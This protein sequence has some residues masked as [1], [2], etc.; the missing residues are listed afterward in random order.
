MHRRKC[1]FKRLKGA[2]TNH[3]TAGDVRGLFRACCSI[4][5][6]VAIMRFKFK[7]EIKMLKHY[8]ALVFVTVTLTIS[9]QAFASRMEQIVEG[10]SRATPVNFHTLEGRLQFGKCYILESPD[11]SKNALFYAFTRDKS[12]GPLF[13]SSTHNVSLI[14][15]LVS[16]AI[17]RSLSVATR[18]RS[19]HDMMNI[20]RDAFLPLK[21]TPDGVLNSVASSGQALLSLK[22]DLSSRYLY[23]VI[24]ALGDKHRHPR[25][26]IVGACY[27]YLDI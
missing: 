24:E 22:E 18:A 8:T 12:D 10:F 2:I 13:P 3:V 14:E 9:P 20:P 16:E 6:F 23:A 19:I 11:S 27:F 21:E 4:S 15:S 25:G 5:L 26:T 7:G 17:A 1:A